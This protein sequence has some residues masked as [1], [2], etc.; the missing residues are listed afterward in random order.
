MKT[1]RPTSALQWPFW[2]LIAAWVCANSPQ[3]GVYAALSW[4]AEARTFTHQ[5]RLVAEVAHLLG[6][7]EAVPSAIAQTVARARSQDTSRPVPPVPADAV[8]KKIPLVLE[9]T[10]EF[11]PPALR[12]D[13]PRAASEAIPELLRAP[14]PH[15]PPRVA[16][17]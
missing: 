13:Y 8:L 2:L 3:A 9:R 14:P 16:T 5:Q 7:G 1:R 17:A 4:L 12:A 11:L 6:G 15:G 10:A